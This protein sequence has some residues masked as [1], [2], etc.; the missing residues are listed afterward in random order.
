MHEGWNMVVAFLSSGGDGHHLFRDI[1]LILD[2]F[3]THVCSIRMFH[4]SRRISG[5]HLRS[6]AKRLDNMVA[7]IKAVQEFRMRGR[8]LSENNHTM[9]P[10]VYQPLPHGQQAKRAPRARPTR[11]LTTAPRPP[12]DSRRRIS[13]SPRSRWNSR[14]C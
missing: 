7:C 8:I 12:S 6:E 10:L 1:Y 4:R 5:S 3:F 11:V 9:G 2:G 14:R 13:T